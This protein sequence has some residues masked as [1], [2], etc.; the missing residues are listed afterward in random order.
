MLRIQQSV[1][2]STFMRIS[3]PPRFYLFLLGITFKLQWIIP[4]VPIILLLLSSRKLYDLIKLVVIAAI[5]F[6]VILKLEPVPAGILETRIKSA[7]H[8]TSQMTANVM[9]RP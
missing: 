9:G 1:D 5:F 8:G 4:C 7:R 6:M 3:L 2:V